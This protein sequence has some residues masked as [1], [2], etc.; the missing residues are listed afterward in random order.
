MKSNRQQ[1]PGLLGDVGFLFVVGLLVFT[2]GL[3]LASNYIET[4]T[5]SIPIAISNEDDS[6]PPEA[7]DLEAWFQYESQEI[8]AVRT[9]S[10]RPEWQVLIYVDA[11]LTAAQGLPQAMRALA[12]N[13]DNLVDLGPTRI[14]LADP[15]PKVYL[16]TTSDRTEL[17][18]AL[19]D[20][21]TDAMTTGELEWLR[22]RFLDLPEDSDFGGEAT[23]ALRNEV[24]LVERQRR[25]LL[26]ILARDSGHGPKLLVL[27]QN[28][29]DLNPRGFYD[30]QSGSSFLEDPRSDL[31]Y[32]SSQRAVA[33]EGWTVLVIAGGKRSRVLEDPLAPLSGLADATGGLLATRQKDA[34]N[35]LERMQS[36]PIL[37]VTLEAE[38]SSAPQPFVVLDRNTRMPVPTSRW[39]SSGPEAASL[40]ALNEPEAAIEEPMSSRPVIELLKPQNVAV[41]GHLRLR[42]ISGRRRIDRVQFLLDGHE[43]AM[44]SRSPFATTVDLGD[45]IRPCEVTAIAYSKSGRPLGRDTL[46]LNVGLEPE[47]VVITE[48]VVD[49]AGQEIEIAAEANSPTGEL[50]ACDKPALNSQRQPTVSHHLSILAD[51]GLLTREQRGKWAWFK[52]VPDRVAVLRDALTS[53]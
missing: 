2:L 12:H 23:L 31:S 42:T 38:A 52:V 8:L 20:I 4:R 6:W 27:V 11:P 53:P 7:T 10:E 28:G 47:K 34:T 44:D 19:R 43:I 16:E 37:E 22:Q 3:G 39:A 18:E 29:F 13:T 24:D 40:L 21:V 25:S 26:Q 14:V 30:E 49:S 36:W 45:E 41:S 9:G 1:I 48:L 5:I 15:A 46:L 17:R 35:L 51:A 33:S 32:E 50:C